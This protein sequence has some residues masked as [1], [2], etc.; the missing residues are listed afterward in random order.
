M[1]AKAEV[2]KIYETILSS[3]GMADLVKISI[4]IPRKNVLLLSKVIER[5]VEGKNAD[6]KTNSMLEF[7]PK[8]I[9]QE[10]HSISTEILQ[11]EGLAE[12][13]EKLKA[14]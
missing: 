11:K 12:M 9:I 2:T 1:L 6:E 13:N 8:E 7:I 14:F 4:Q 5:G 3:S 10:L